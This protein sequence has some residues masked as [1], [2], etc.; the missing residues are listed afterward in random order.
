MKSFNLSNINK[1]KKAAG[2]Y[3][4][5]NRDRR[6][7]YNGSSKNIK[8]R[9]FAV[10]YGRADWAQI[11]AKIQMR[12]NKQIAFYDVQ[13]MPIKNARARDRRNNKG[14]PQKPIPEGIT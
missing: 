3:V 9:L 12:K 1:E 11:P 4:Y 6:K 10:Y 13:Y 7:T 5:Y 8:Q 14:I 2:Y